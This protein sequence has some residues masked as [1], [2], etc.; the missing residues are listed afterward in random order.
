MDDFARECLAL[1]AD[2]SLSGRRVARELDRAGRLR[3]L[4]LLAVSDNGRMD[5][6]V[7][8]TPAP[9]GSR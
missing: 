6:V 5:E 2:A 7:S 1:V 8:L 9:D 4:P 3:G